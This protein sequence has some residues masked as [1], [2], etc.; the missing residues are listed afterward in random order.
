MD[1]K[2]RIEQQLNEFPVLLY[3]KGTPDFPQC[4]FSAQVVGALKQCQKRFAY[5]NILEDEELREGLKTYSSWPTFP[6]LYVS[7]ELLGGCDIIVEMFESGELQKS[8]N[9]VE[10]G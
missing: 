8:L 4:G 7:G 5:V 6:Q 10:E 1:I 2:V 9:V 3:M